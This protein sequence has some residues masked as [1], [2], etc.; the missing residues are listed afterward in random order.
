VV[1]V[2]HRRHQVEE[3]AAGGERDLPEKIFDSLVGRR[4]PNSNRSVVD[5]VRRVAPT[6]RFPRQVQLARE[7]VRRHVCES[8]WARRQGAID[9]AY[10]SRAK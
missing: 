2:A 3:R 1:D 4:A 9:D 10:A 7:L 8:A 6:E 5:R